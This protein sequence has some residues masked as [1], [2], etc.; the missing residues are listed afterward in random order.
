M[1]NEATTTNT[2]TV[3]LPENYCRGNLH[4]QYVKL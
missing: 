2:Y 3:N 4:S 1:V